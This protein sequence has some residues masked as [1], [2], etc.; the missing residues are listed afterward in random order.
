MAE[1]RIHNRVSIIASVPTGILV[2]LRNPI[3][4][5]GAFLGC[6]LGTILTPD[7]DQIGF[8]ANEWGLV[9]TLGPLGFIWA[10]IWWLYTL[11]PHRSPLSH[12]PVLGTAIRIAY[13]VAVLII[14]WIIVGR[15]VLVMPAWGWVLL[16][17]AW[18]GLLVSDTGHFLLDL[19]PKKGKR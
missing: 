10:A 18:I 3:E 14:I 12:W 8:S 15:P 17:G 1:G 6:L 11:I 7:L 4:G 2:G 19:L 16:R 5:I 13:S 9:K